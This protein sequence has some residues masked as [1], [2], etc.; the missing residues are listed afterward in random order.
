MHLVP[1]HAPLELATPSGAMR[2]HVVRPAAPGRYPG[3]VLW[4]EIFQATGPIMRTAAALAGNV[5]ALVLVPEVYHEALP[6]GTVLPYTADGAARGNELKAAKDVAAWDADAAA[7]VAWL[8]ASPHCSGRVAT[9]GLC[10]GGGLALR[11][12]LHP[13]VAATVC[14]YATDVHKGTLGRGD[15][16]LAR[17][18]A[19]GARGALMLVWGRQDPHVPLEGR[20][21]LHD[22]LTGAGTAFDWHEW[23]AAAHAFMRDEGSAGRHDPELAT[24][25]HTLAAAFLRRHVGG[26][27][28]PA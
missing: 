12:A 19:G 22:A 6:A 13:A 21:A 26:P 24:L 11:T 7:C 16:T 10:L 14:W 28:P 20:R 18:A 17:L 4:S 25:C 15:D 8:L 2:V 23:H 27:L 5:G 1:D 3:V 9:V